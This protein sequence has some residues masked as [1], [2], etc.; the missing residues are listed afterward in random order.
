[1]FYILIVEDD[2]EFLELFFII[3]VKNG[4]KIICVK[5]GVEVFDILDKEYIDLIIFDVMMFNMDGFELF[6]NI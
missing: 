4:Y 6:K 2:K 3:L 5:D 1:M